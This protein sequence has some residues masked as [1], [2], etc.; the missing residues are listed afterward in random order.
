VHRRR[1]TLAAVL[2]PILLQG[3]NLAPHYQVPATAPPAAAYQETGPWTPAAPADAAPRGPWWTVF[4]DPTLNGLEERIEQASPRLAAA[5]ARHDQ[6]LAEARIARADLFPTVQAN[7]DGERARSLQYGEEHDYAGGGSLSYEVDLWGRVRNNVAAGRA[8]AQ[9]SAEDLASV[10]LSLQAELAE[11]YLQLR[12]LDAQLAVLR[13]TTDAYA[14]ALDLTERRFAGGASSEL[15][16]GRAR[17]QFADA[18]SQLDQAGADRAQYE[19]AVADL[20]GEQVSGFSIP[21]ADTQTDPPRIPI[22]APS[23]L[24]QRRP[25]IAAAERR[26]AAANARI[27]VARAAQYPSLQLGGSGGYEAIAGT[28]LSVA[29]PVWALGPA[30]SALTLFDA[31]RHRAE[32]A[33]TRAVFDEA[34]A[35]YR[36]T[37]LDAFRD[38]EDQLA[39]ANR[40]ARAEDRE[41]EAVAAAARTD[42]L[43]A[44]QYKDGAVDYLQVVVAQ[45]AELTAR[46]D[47]IELR[48]RRLLAGV[49]LIR[50][51]GGGWG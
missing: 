13:Q 34:A 50:A 28:L 51:L 1:R 5:V 31:G 45:T 8:D 41:R 46:R 22:A 37:V 47:A 6:A 21:P 7:A 20:V 26:V 30:M 33:R 39:L 3:C 29:G 19:H 14:Q 27:G 18:Q 10:R 4:G 15:D 35:N 17:T 38:V 36:Q 11:D 24:L 49:D 2:T 40:L 43:A 32:I 16:V 23:L 9:A 12:G 48:T 25:D 44:V 42:Q